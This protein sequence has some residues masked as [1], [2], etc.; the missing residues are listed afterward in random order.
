[1]TAYT[2]KAQDKS[3]S[4]RFL[5]KT[6]K[7]NEAVL[8]QY[9]TQVMGKWGTYIDG[10]GKPVPHAVAEGTA[11]PVETAPEVVVEVV[12][13]PQEETAPPAP[14]AFGSF[15]LNQL[16]AASNTQA[17]ADQQTGRAVR[18]GTTSTSGLKIEK[19]RQEQNGMRRR[20]TG[21]VTHKLWSMYDAI[22]R[23]CTLEQAKAAASQA[24]LSTT[25]AAIA[26]YN[27]RRFNGIP[28]VR[29]A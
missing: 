18:E 28:S 27:W 4:R 13:A 24:G 25:S 3:N 16:T 14:D 8:D 19:D 9:M 29:K 12:A 6:C 22:G 10:E 7:L 21:T 2:F 20:S 26:L 15:A 1:M 23:T 5:T 17:P 11:A